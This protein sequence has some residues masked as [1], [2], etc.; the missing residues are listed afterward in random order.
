MT[1]SLPFCFFALVPR[2]WELA[3]LFFPSMT[4]LTGFPVPAGATTDAI[5]EDRRIDMMIEGRANIQR[6]TSCTFVIVLLWH[7]LAIRVLILGEAIKV[8]VCSVM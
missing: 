7:W 5:L 1:A 4:E 8:E 3:G 2:A 6:V